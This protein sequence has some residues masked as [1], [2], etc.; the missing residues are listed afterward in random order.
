MYEDWSMEELKDERRAL[1]EKIAETERCA[2]RLF[3]RI[4]YN[5]AIADD[6][7]K[8]ADQFYQDWKDV[9]EEMKRREIEHERR[10]Q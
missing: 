10:A 4:G 5:E 1:R 7:D 9:N 8:K 2:D 3:E 6:Y